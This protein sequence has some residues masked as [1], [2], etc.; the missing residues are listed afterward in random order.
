MHG[1]LRLL[2]KWDWNKFFTE[3]VIVYRQALAFPAAIPEKSKFKITFLMPKVQ[4]TPSEYPFGKILNN[5]R[6]YPRFITKQHFI[7][8]T[9][10]QFDKLLKTA[11]KKKKNSTTA[12][13]KPAV[14]SFLNKVA[15]VLRGFFT[16]VS[17]AKMQREKQFKPS[18][19]L[20]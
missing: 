6:I 11:R 5:F 12:E 14:L 3:D 7:M 16:S 17:R 8:Q 19:K 2:I 4:R 15:D 10:F 1:L 9:I 18:R 13:A 20:R